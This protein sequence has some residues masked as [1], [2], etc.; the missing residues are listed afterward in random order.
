MAGVGPLALTCLF[1]G[2]FM[3]AMKNYGIMKLWNYGIMLRIR[4]PAS[5][6]DELWNIFNSKILDLMNNY[7]PTK[8]VQSNAKQSWINHNVKKY[9]DANKGFTTKQDQLT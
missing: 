1:I 8:L 7:I 9:D 4:L 6:V 2:V 5:S 3:E